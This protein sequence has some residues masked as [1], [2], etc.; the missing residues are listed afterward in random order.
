M[1]ISQINPTVI[2]RSLRIV[3]ISTAGLGEAIAAASGSAVDAS[4]IYADER[5]YA[6]RVA[7]EGLNEGLQRTYEWGFW[8]AS[9]VFVI[10][11]RGS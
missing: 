1:Q 3:S 7:G 2:P 11:S 8:G 10:L 9:C 5:E 6:Q 4:V